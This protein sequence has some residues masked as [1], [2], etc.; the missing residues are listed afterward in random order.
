[1]AENIKKGVKIKAQKA[2]LRSFGLQRETYVK[3]VT[4]PTH[5]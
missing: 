1:M 4:R 5:N 2:K 3:V